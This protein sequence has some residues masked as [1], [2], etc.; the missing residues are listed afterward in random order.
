MSRTSTPRVLRPGV[1]VTVAL[2]ALLLSGA[3]I[4][5]VGEA[6]RSPS[7]TDSLPDGYDSTTVTEL[8]AELPSGEGSVALALF[9]SDDGTLDR[10]TL[11][12]LETV[13]GSLVTEATAGAE[14]GPPPGTE[15]GGLQ[16]SEDGT[17]AIGV[18]PVPVEGATETA[19]VVADLRGVLDADVPD[20]VT[21]SL[22]GPA[23]IEADLAGVFDGADLTL[24]AATA[25][26]VAVLLI[27]TYRSPFLWLV[28]LAVVGIADRVAAV[29]ATHTLAAFEVAWDESTVGILSVLVF[30]AGTDYALLLISRYRDELRTHDN[31]YAAMAAAVRGTAEAV[32]AS[33]TTV[34][35][36]LLTLLLS[37]VPTTRGLGLAC[38]VGVVVAATFA[39]V[40]LPCALV[41]FGRWVFWPLVPR[42]G[43]PVLV[44]SRSSLWRRLGDRVAG[45]PARF[46]TVAVLLVAGL[47]TGLTQVEQGLS[48]SE[49]F[50]ETPESIVAAERLGESFPAG[51][52]D[53]T[54]V[55]TRS[56]AEE[57]LRAAEQ[58]DGVVSATPGA[59]SDDLARIDVVLD[60]PAG[61]EAAQAAIVELRGELSSYDDTWVGGSEAQ[62]VDAIAGAERD[63]QLLIPLILALV[64]LGLTLLLRSLVA[65]LLLVA[66]VVGTFFAALG[67]SWWIYTGVFGF[68]AID[69]GVPLLAFLFL[70]A[71]GVDY[72]IFLVTRALQ[73]AGSHGV[74]EGMLR[75]L[76]ATGGVITS[77]G[78]LLAAVFAVL[79]VLPLVVLAQLGIV[80]FVG[81]LL[82][83]LVV[84]T[85]LV[86]ALALILGERFWWPRRVTGRA[87][88]SSAVGEDAVASA[89]VRTDPQEQASPR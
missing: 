66:T 63:R 86:P 44:D 32:L 38:A 27:I 56:D 59:S 82:D 51:T 31:R 23:A 34:V 9:T 36:G 79:G 81:V 62:A 85:V 40:V 1:A 4:G 2:L 24:L 55:L 73:E 78:I 42:V 30:G 57:V 77:A 19:D 20:G 7:A 60:A 33:S 25:T 10:A 26:V 61:S 3:L 46:A 5:A 18:V 14:G 75:A 71:L 16:V 49:Q 37:V 21:G 76:T 8:S 47:A 39:L 45:H 43:Q 88:G 12:E 35:L 74:R 53:P 29:A 84:R 6:E 67:A 80:I 72:N 17:A 22:T 48:Q 28:P 65:P 50:L 87:T 70:V 58:T 11:A 52:V 54:V 15:G 83:T 69:V 89:A 13:Y 41:L 68:E 64:L